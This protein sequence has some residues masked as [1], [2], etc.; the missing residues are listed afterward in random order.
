MAIY[1]WR[2]YVPKE[3]CFTANTA[4]STVQL[5]KNWS[6]ATVTLETSTDWVNW[7]TYTTWSTITLSNIWDKV[8][9][10]NTSTTD[11]QFDTDE[12]NYYKFVMSWSIAWSW[13]ITSLINKN[14][15][16]YSWYMCYLFNWCT[17]LTSTPQLPATSL[18]STWC[19]KSMFEWCTSLIATPELPATTLANECYYN[20]F[21]N[22]TSLTDVQPLQA[23]TMTTWCYAN[24]FNG[25]TSLVNAP[26]LKA[27]TLNT[28]C[29]Q[30]MFQNCTSLQS[31]PKLI[32]T[33][34]S[35][36]AYF[37]MFNW[38]SKIK[39]SSNQTWAYQTVYRIPT[40]W[41]WTAWSSALSNMFQ[42]TWWTF[43]WT[44]SVNTTYYTSNTVV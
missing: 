3:L 21:K 16:N 34:I 41:T 7:S 39:M 24:M 33:S 37:R 38:C 22:C 36:Q 29:Y 44:P 35:I 13:D 28:A 26:E 27:T 10:R 20:M 9:W 43:T 40:T 11:V 23:T 17:S 12:W 19:Y 42:N 8:Y 32:A 25:C 4:G 14:L 18:Y 6:P 2:E 30:M 5:S 15:T 1:M 31:I